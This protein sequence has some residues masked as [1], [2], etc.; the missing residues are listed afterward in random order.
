VAVAGELPKDLP[1][2]VETPGC[3]VHEM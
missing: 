1:A 3:C 2:K